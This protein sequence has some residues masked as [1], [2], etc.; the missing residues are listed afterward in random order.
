MG[1]LT[2]EEYY[3]ER[4]RS[5][6][7]DD[8]E[9]I[10]RYEKALAWMDLVGVPVI[11]EIGCKFGE[12]NRM[13]LS[14]GKDFK[15]KAVDIDQATL[16]KIPEYNK[17]QFICENVNNGLPFSDESADYIVCM[18]VMEHLENATLFLYEVRRV[19]KNGGK[20][21]LSVP[22]PY[23]WL[24]IFSNMRKR[25][26][27]EGHIATYTYQNINA[28]MN[29][30]SLKLLDTTGTFTRVPFTRRLFGKSSIFKTNIMFLTRN[31]VFLIEK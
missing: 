23:C 1:N 26:D 25:E 28:L 8:Q 4:G 11:Y 16:Q 5:Y 3:N 24:E 27:T 30:S 10:I 13:L 31:Y 9:A 18:E 14:S 2:K 17:E 6:G 12:L 21:I 20:L 22:N 19:L 15:Y 29:F 7:F